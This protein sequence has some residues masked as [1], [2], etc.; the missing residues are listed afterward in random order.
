MYPIIQQITS[1]FFPPCCLGCSYPLADN[2]KLICTKCR[3]Q[4]PLTRIHQEDSAMVE[5]MFYG[6]APVEKA[7]AMLWFEKQGIVQHLIHQLKYKNQEE[8]GVFLGSWLGVEL[9]EIPHYKTIN[10]V[11][12]VPLH[13]KKYRKRGYNQVAAFGREIARRLE[14]DYLETVLV[15][16]QYTHTQTYK[17]RILRWK[18]VHDIFSLN[19]PERIANKH[20]LL[21][22][23][24][25]TTGATLEACL[26][27]L[28]KGEN[29]SVSIAAMA[30]TV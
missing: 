3:H 23:D 28:L 24:V 22:D 29:V 21:V 27:V 25:I 1:L 19:H 17:N 20:L 9:A 5:K 2:E 18:N 30:L 11:I 4:L 10:A 16:K 8:I 15:R 12:P 7:T 6:K 13:P 14:A 26:H